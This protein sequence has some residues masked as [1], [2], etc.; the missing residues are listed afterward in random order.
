MDSTAPTTCRCGRPLGP[1]QRRFCS[2]E[3][4]HEAQRAG[5]TPCPV[6]G[7]R[8]PARLK[9]CSKACWSED[10][11][12]HDHTCKRCGVEFASTKKEQSYCTRECYEAEVSTGGAWRLRA[13]RV[14][15]AARRARKRAN[16]YVRFDPLR[17]LDRDGWTC[18]IC[19]TPTP[20]RLRGTFEDDAPELDHVVPLSQGG[21]H[22]PENT[23]CACRRCNL[24]KAATAVGQLALALV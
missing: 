23:Q 24:D 1:R 14:S 10:P 9:Y 13:N 2:Q 7:K 19:G 16:G 3:C 15:S 4:K 20:R 17:V 18:Q 6:C 21:P 5:Q 8:K 11:V 22:T 12:R